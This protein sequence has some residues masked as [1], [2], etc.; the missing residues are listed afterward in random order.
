LIPS[1]AINSSLRKSD[2]MFCIRGHTLT[3][4]LKILKLWV[5]HPLPAPPSFSNAKLDEGAVNYSAASR[6]WMEATNA[7][8]LSL[9]RQR[10]ELAIVTSQN[11]DA[12]WSSASLRPAPG[13]RA[14]C[15]VASQV[16]AGGF[17]VGPMGAARR[18]P[19]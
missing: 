2:A 9:W 3:D 18:P 11:C 15:A 17:S 16:Q 10:E 5:F 13:I 14:V 7:W 8:L 6:D 4:T 19:L 1:S 12:P